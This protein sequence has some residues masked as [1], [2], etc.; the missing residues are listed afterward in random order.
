[1]TKKCRHGLTDGCGQLK[2]WGD[3]DW[4]YQLTPTLHVGMVD[5]CM[6]F[7]HEGGRKPW[8]ISLTLPKAITPRDVDGLPKKGTSVL[9][10]EGDVVAMVRYLLEGFLVQFDD[11]G[12][13]VNGPELDT[14]IMLAIQEKPRRKTKTRAVAK[15]SPRRRQA[16]Q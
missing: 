7:G 6:R 1:M 13:P 16:R 10:S 2:M 11:D 8:N 3:F 4:S 15:A 5:E 9:L 14:N 12:Q